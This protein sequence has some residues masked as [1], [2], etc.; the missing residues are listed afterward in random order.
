MAIY[1]HVMLLVDIIIVVF[2]PKKKCIAQEKTISQ[3]I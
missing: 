1:S 2:L 3:R